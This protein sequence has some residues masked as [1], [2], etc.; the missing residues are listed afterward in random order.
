MWRAPGEETWMLQTA[1]PS[2]E[3]DL[4]IKDFWTAVSARRTPTLV[5]PPRRFGVDSA[6]LREGNRRLA[7]RDNSRRKSGTG[8]GNA[9]SSA[10]AGETAGLFGCCAKVSKEKEREQ[11][12]TRARSVIWLL[13]TRKGSQA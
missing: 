3:T 1:R 6:G 12:I 2:G 7:G 10:C 13:T 5:R 8:W 11:A 9:G 4:W